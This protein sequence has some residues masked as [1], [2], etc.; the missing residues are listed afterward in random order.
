MTVSRYVAA[1]ATLP[2]LFWSQLR[3]RPVRSASRAA[4]PLPSRALKASSVDPGYD[5]DL[6]VEADSVQLQRW[7]IRLAPFREL[8]A[9]GHA[10]LLGPSKLARAF[11]TWFDTSGA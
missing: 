1:M 8:V 5:V 10:R 6:A 11:P 4:R 9:S 7:L 2:P 3:A